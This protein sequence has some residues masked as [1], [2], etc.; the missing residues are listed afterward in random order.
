MTETGRGWPI[1]LLLALP[2]LC[3]TIGFELAGSW[4]E[5]PADPPTRLTAPKR[6][7]AVGTAEPSNQR[8]AWF[9]TILSRPLFN[10]DRKP[11]GLDAHT[12]RG[13]TRLTGII[14][15]GS[16]RVAVFAAP[17]GGRAIVVEAGAHIGAYDVLD[18][19]D[20]G[21]TV[22]GPEGTT[23]IRPIFDVAAAAATKPPSPTRA[24]L[25]KPATK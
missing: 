24:A 20:A 15:T 1:G 13:L 17:S 22:T 12:V 21:V 11:I 8:D 5:Q 7:A 3:A 23:V 10:P 18:I 19:T 25:P 2:I 6:E 14:I 9:N 16:R 4:Q